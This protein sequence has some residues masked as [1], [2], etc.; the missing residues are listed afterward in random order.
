MFNDIEISRKTGTTQVQQMKVP[1]NYAPKQKILARID[2]NLQNN[3]PAITL[4]R[5]SFEMT[6]MTYAPDRK[7]T[8][9]TKLVRASAADGTMTSMFAPAP[10]DI[11]FQLNVMTKYNEDGTKI[12]EQI[13]PYFK[14]DCTVSVKL[15][16]ELE[17][18]F[19][20]PIVLNSVSQEDTYEG[21]FE[22]RRALIWTLSFTMKGYFFGPVSTRKQITFVDADIYPTT[23]I[24]S[25][26]SYTNLVE[27]EEYT[28]SN[29]GAGRNW[30]AIGADSDPAV[31]EVFTVNDQLSSYLN[32]GTGGTATPTVRA[33]GS[34]ITV[35]PGLLIDSPVVTGDI[36][37]PY[38]TPLIT[39]L[40]PGKLYSL[41]SLDP[42]DYVGATPDMDKVQKH[43]SRYLGL[44][45]D[46]KHKVGDVIT[47]PTQEYI[48]SLSAG[49]KLSVLTTVPYSVRVSN[50]V[51]GQIADDTA[52]DA[53]TQ[54]IGI[55][56]DWKAMVVINDGDGDGATTSGVADEHE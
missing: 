44:P 51:T 34:Q 26:I 36:N 56:D 21:D 41:Y 19:D 45:D 22:S 49:Q 4:P 47:A 31:G 9:V 46:T 14:P 1:I 5:M 29:L 16:D 6:G 15:I 55:D 42:K 37:D 35:A 11:E 10:Y 30:N 27:G 23:D 32:T 24:Q 13:L 18:Y 3:A 54:E 2:Q 17:T 38:G 48:D 8:S 50:V 43:L 39:T 20:I 25:N 33:S 28:I 52:R 7:L 12:I 40:T 53:F